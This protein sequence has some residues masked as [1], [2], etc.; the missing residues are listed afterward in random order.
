MFPSLFENLLG[1][2]GLNIPEKQGKPSSPAFCKNNASQ[3]L[4]LQI[5]RERANAPLIACFA[6]FCRLPIRAL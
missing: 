2:V 5:A 6:F 1:T 3:R 4:K